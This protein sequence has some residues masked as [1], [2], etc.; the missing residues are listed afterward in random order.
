MSSCLRKYM[1]KRTF[2]IDEEIPIEPAKGWLLIV[3]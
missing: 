1:T 3:E 2:S